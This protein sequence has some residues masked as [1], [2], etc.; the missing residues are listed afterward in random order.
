MRLA[1][2]ITL[3]LLT[4][5][6]SFLLNR[7]ARE[8]FF[9]NKYKNVNYDQLLLAFSYLLVEKISCSVELSMNKVL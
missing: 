9:A 3:K 7:A 5:A 6:N 8:Y 2:L 4:I 1:L